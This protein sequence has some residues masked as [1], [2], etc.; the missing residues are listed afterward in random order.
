MQALRTV[1]W[2]LSVSEDT[3]RSLRTYL[4]L[5]GR[6]K[7]GDLSQAIEEAVLS[8]IFDHTARQIKDGCENIG[9]DDIDSL[10]GEAL[11]W[12]RRD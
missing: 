7:K 3:D 10:V 11:D 6:G 12:A 2:N 9:E 4:A 5:N 1:R 8:Y